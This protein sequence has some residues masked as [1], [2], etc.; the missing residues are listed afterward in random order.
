ML[1]TLM[2]SGLLERDHLGFEEALELP[3]VEDQEMIQTCS[4]HAQEKPFT[5]GMRPARLRYGVR[6]TL[7]PL[8]VA[9]RAPCGPH[10]RSLSRINSV[11]VCPSGVASRSGTC[12]PKVGR[13]SRHMD[14]DAFPRFH[15]ADEASKERTEDEGSRLEAHRR[16]TSLGHAGG[17]P[18]SSVVHGLAHGAHLLPLLLKSPFDSPAYPV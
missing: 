6:S 17:R 10:F 13:R 18:F 8:V 11:G 12:H 14:L 1:N 5:D 15:L 3:L 9:T 2:W 16:P 7:M 4:P